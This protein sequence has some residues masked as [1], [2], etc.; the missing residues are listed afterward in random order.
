MLEKIGRQD[1]EREKET[2]SQKIWKYERSRKFCRKKT[3]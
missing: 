2:Y 1:L 3:Q